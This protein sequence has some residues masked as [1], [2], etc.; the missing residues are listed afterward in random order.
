MINFTQNNLDKSSSPYLQQHKNNPIHWQEWTKETLEEAKKQNKL[1]LISIGYATCHWC[2]VMAAEAFSNKEIAGYLNNKFIAIKIDR[3]QRPDI[4]QYFMNFITE[5]QGHG[6]WPLN[7]IVTPDTKPFMAFTY[8]PET[9][10][11]GMPSFLDAITFA[12]EQY[13]KN[14]NEIPTF[15]AEQTTEPNFEEQKIIATIKN[16][17]DSQNAGFGYGPKFPPH[18]TLFYLLHYYEETNDE[19]AKQMIIATLDTMA[20]KGLHDHLQGGFYRYCTD[21]NWTIPHFEKMLYDQAMLLM[22]YSAAYK[23]FKKEEY[24]T[25]AEKIIFCLEKTFEENNVYYSGHDAD[26]NHK[27]GLTYLWTKQE[28][29]KKLTEQEFS[30]LKQLYEISDSGNFENKIHLIKNNNFSSHTLEKLEKSNIEKIEEKLLSLRKKREQ[31]FTDKKIITNWNCLAGIGFIYAYRYTNNEKAK[32]KSL[33]LFYEI[34]KKHYK[35]KKLIHSSLNNQLQEQEFLQDYAAFLLF[36]TYIYE[37]TGEEKELLE[38]LKQKLQQFKK[39]NHWIES[40][41]NDFK[42][43][44]AQNFDH[45]TPSSIS[46]AE[47]ALLRTAILTEKEYA[48]MNYRQPLQSDFYN[49]A[50]LISQG[51][52][53]IIHTKEK[54]DWQQLP[55]NTIQIQSNHYQDCYKT[56]CREFK[57]KEKIIKEI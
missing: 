10:K 24:K 5:T 42:E 50:A 32:N 34:K 46:L 37:E 23:I 31:P 29:Q 54:I 25:I 41:N 47:L 45:P 30:K 6:G 57:S 49:I 4:D 51:N 19:T 55:L 14:K 9:A 52:F 48:T 40:N 44:E 12:E 13:R 43:I 15:T 27:E 21:R 20:A 39:N 3:E 18:N 16:A 26:T 53:H 17:Y 35:N 28:L 33:T 8:L 1:I 7:C 56:I 11:Q 2:H 36:T 22:V 38:E